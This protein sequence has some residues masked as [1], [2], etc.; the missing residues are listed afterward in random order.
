[1]SLSHTGGQLVQ[2]D[3]QPTSGSRTALPVEEKI[4][5]TGIVICESDSIQRIVAMD[6]SRKQLHAVQLVM[7]NLTMRTRGCNVYLSRKPCTECAKW[8][9]QGEVLSVSFWSKDPEYSFTNRKGENDSNKV[10]QIFKSSS[11]I[12]SPH[13]PFIDYEKVTTKICSRTR[14]QKCKEC[15]TST[16]NL[17]LK[18]ELFNNWSKLDMVSEI[19]ENILKELIE[20]TVHCYD[21]L[22]NCNH[23]SITETP[24][25]TRDLAAHSLQLCFL[26]AA[27]SDDPHRGVGAIIY[28]K[29]QFIVAAGYNGYIKKATYGNFPRCGRNSQSTTAKASSMV[30][31]EVNAL[32]FRSDTDVDSAVLFSSKIP[33]TNCEKMINTSGIKTVVSVKD[34][35]QCA[36]KLGESAKKSRDDAK[37]SRDGTQELRDCTQ[38][39]RDGAEKLSEGVNIILWEW[40]TELQGIQQDKDRSDN[41]SPLSPVGPIR[42]PSKGDLLMYLALLMEN[43]P[44]CVKPKEKDGIEFCKTG[45]TIFDAVGTNQIRVIDCCRNDLHAV[46]QALLSF[47]HCLQGCEVY[48]SRHPCTTC[49]KLL[50]QGGVHHVRYWPNLEQ[51]QKQKILVNA[52]NVNRL[53][54]EGKVILEMYIPVLD[55]NTVQEKISPKIR[56]TSPKDPIKCS[57]IFD[58]SDHELKTVLK[59]LDL[60]HIIEKDYKAIFKEQVETAFKCLNALQFSTAGQFKNRSGNQ[61]LDVETV[62]RHSLALQLCFLLAARTDSAS[63][64]VGAL[65]YQN[66][67]FVGIGY[68]GFPRGNRCSQY[69]P[70][71]QELDERACQSRKGDSKKKQKAAGSPGQSTDLL[72]CAEANALY[73]RT[74]RWLKDAVIYSS[75]YP[76]DECMALIKATKGITHIICV[77]PKDA[78]LISCPE[79][80]ILYT[81]EQDLGITG[82][83]NKQLDFPS[84]QE[85]EQEC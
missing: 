38:E 71:C 16:P 14:R 63:H 6:C 24:S 28:N 5:K 78:G 65:I 3:L 40:P 77:P 57:S 26:L 15:N 64:G 52:T 18:D 66:D 35:K 80:I 11:I 37:K 13:V 21:A 4:N 33:C 47:P 59:A 53:F 8:L 41:T 19:E 17:G 56:V 58:L 27:R 20:R 70:H 29:K 30:H 49:A 60:S 79:D 12:A 51:S 81:W 25:F 45:I 36:E 43:S 42:L 55:L 7:M 46:Q 74:E 44:L 67:C 2:A 50:I 22:L 75:S 69:L 48:L 54:R 68:N 72:I 39:S 76:C 23:G 82:M 1:M 62:K 85:P 10:N 32:L 83:V 73:F 84:A 61:N 9:V 34:L 31:A